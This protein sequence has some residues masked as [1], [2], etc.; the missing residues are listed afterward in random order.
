MKNNGELTGDFKK[1]LRDRAGAKVGNYSNVG[2]EL[3]AGMNKIMDSIDNHSDSF[4]AVISF[5]HGAFE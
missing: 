2:P 1:V 5:G 4:E 3:R